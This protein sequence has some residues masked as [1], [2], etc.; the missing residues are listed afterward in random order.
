MIHVDIPHRSELEKL[1][2]YRGNAC[3]SIYLPTTPITR[4][5]QA[6]RIALKNAA[7]TAVEQLRAADTPSR[8]ISA[9]EEAIDDLVDDDEFWAHQARSVAIF[10]T[11]ERSMTFRLPTTLTSIVEV[12]DRFHIKPLLRSVT[13]PQSAYV[14]ALAQGAVRLI[15]VTGDLPAATVSVPGLPDDAASAVGLPSISGRAP[16]GRIQGSEG[17]KVRLRQYAKRVDDALRNFL[18]GRETPL[19]L[20]ATRPIDYIFRSVNSYP[21]LAAQG[22][23]VQP[24]KMSDD[25]LATAARGVLDQLHRAELTAI[26]ARFAALANSGRTT[27]DVAEAARAATAGAVEL[28]LADIDEVLSGTVDEQGKVTRSAAP[29]A[30]EYGVVDEIA[31]RAFMSGARVLG[32]RRAD[33]PSGGS[34][35]AILRNPLP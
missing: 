23:S 31:N 13:W 24:E 15:E 11:P 30:T 19:I 1:I 2:A 10:V 12:A 27:T 26:H 29:T 20:A 35:A 14:L 16:A 4:D 22:L 18:Q 28:M 6:D 17:K 5:A 9:I 7:R 34:V 8:D 32:V 21:N 25:D 33:V 3:I